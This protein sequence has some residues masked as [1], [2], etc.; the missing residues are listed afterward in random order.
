MQLEKRFSPHTLGWIMCTIGALFYCYE[1]FLRSSPS[2]MMI[3]LPLT[4]VS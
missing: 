4:R 2:V 1:F 3:V